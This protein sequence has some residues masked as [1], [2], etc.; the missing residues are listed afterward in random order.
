MLE[1]WGGTSVMIGMALEGA[2]SGKRFLQG[3]AQPKALVGI[4]MT[5]KGLCGEED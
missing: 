1:R 2:R 3:R 5:W 4:A